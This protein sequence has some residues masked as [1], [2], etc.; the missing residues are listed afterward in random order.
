MKLLNIPTPLPLHPCPTRANGGFTYYLIGFVQ[1][2]NSQHGPKTLFL[3]SCISFNMIRVGHSPH[4]KWPKKLN[5]ASLR[6]SIFAETCGPN[7][8]KPETN[9][10]TLNDLGMNHR[11]ESHTNDRKPPTIWRFQIYSSPPAGEYVEQVFRDLKRVTLE[12]DGSTN[13]E[14]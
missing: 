2:W 6:S 10:Y 13:W 7:S 8:N 9:R 4:L 1:S 3:Q 12:V 14:I 11:L 5:V